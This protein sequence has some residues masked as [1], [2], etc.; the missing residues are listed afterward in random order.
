MAIFMSTA[1]LLRRLCIPGAA[2]PIRLALHLSGQ[3][4][5][6]VR[7]AGENWAVGELKS[8]T[9]PPSS[10]SS[11]SSSATARRARIGGFDRTAATCLPFRN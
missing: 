7:H 6:D 5:E 9:I 8:S 1:K 11:S 10:S 4:F 2:E 3:E